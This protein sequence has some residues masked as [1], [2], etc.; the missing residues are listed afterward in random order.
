M[1]PG[2]WTGVAA[3]FVA[4]IIFALVTLLG[5]FN[6]LRKLLL[7][8]LDKVLFP[9]TPF[10][11]AGRLCELI[12]ESIDSYSGDFSKLKLLRALPCE[13]SLALVD[14]LA[15]ETGTGARAEAAV[16]RYDQ[17]LNAV[18]QESNGSFDES[19]FGRTG[20]I[21]LDTATRHAIER[22]YLLPDRPPGTSVLGLHTN[23]NEIGV[24]LFGETASHR[25][26]TVI[27]WKFGFLLIFSSDFRYVRGYRYKVHQHIANLQLIFEQKKKDSW[28]ENL[29]F[30]MSTQGIS[31]VRGAIDSF[32]S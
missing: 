18:I 16:Q 12:S 2:F 9:V 32:Y 5:L 11:D 22:H 17:L 21:S 13:L 6:P 15:G 24:L 4:S 7:R 30:A 28:Q 14:H 8:Q 1:E 23:L 19:L 26:S 10:A 25:D 31:R 29:L 3:S 27:D 20:V